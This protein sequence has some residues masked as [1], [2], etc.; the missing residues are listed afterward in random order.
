MSHHLFCG[1]AGIYF[2][3]NKFHVSLHTV[4]S[5]KFQDENLHNFRLQLT[6]PLETFHTKA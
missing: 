6:N 4:V 1:D 5:H 3:Y 2:P